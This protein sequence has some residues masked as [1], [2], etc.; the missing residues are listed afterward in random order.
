MPFLKYPISDIRMVIM[1]HFLPWLNQNIFFQFWEI[2]FESFPQA[3]LQIILVSLEGLSDD[4]WNAAFRVIS[5][6]ISIVSVL[7]AF[8]KLFTASPPAERRGVTN[9]NLFCFW[10]HYICCFCCLDSQGRPGFFPQ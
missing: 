7:F 4:L 9:K 8:Y 10:E 5:I 3:A 1:S 6:I 2:L